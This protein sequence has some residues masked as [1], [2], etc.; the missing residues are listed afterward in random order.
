M[1]LGFTHHLALTRE[2]GWRL[3]PDVCLVRDCGLGGKRGAV[4]G[5]AHTGR[6]SALPDK[7][8]FRAISMTQVLV[9]IPA[10]GLPTAQEIGSGN[11]WGLID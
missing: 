11:G 2:L 4:R 3:E 6:L 1:D 7:R 8:F 10:Q 5:W 9:S